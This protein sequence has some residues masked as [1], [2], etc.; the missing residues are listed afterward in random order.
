M[1]Y[2]QIL[3]DLDK[4]LNEDLANHLNYDEKYL[5]DLNINDRRVEIAASTSKSTISEYSLKNDEVS[6]DVI[7][8]FED[9]IT[10]YLKE[11]ITGIDQVNPEFYY[12]LNSIVVM[13]D[14]L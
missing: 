14:L 10:K 4:Y 8:L 3:H 13:F 9:T 2:I 1:E 6:K 12:S 5:V 7:K 11:R